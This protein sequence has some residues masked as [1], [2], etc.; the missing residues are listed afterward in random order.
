M[1]SPDRPTECRIAAGPH[2]TAPFG[3]EP[4]LFTALNGEY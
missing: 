1:E 2:N 3:H 4:E